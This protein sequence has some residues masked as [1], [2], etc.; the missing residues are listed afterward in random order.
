MPGPERTPDRLK[1]PV[2]CGF[3]CRP[4]RFSVAVPW[5]AE[6]DRRLVAGAVG[7]SGPVGAVLLVSESSVGSSLWVSLS[8]E[9]GAVSET[10][11][12]GRTG[13]LE[14]AQAYF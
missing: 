13:S 5:V 11:V 10:V 1:A 4:A 3:R 12:A 8:V 9:E 14:I 7:W 2:E 6:I